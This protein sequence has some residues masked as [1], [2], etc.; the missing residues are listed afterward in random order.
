MLSRTATVT[1]VDAAHVTL[2]MSPQCEGCAACRGRCARWFGQARDYR[3]PRAISPAARIGDQVRVLAGERDVRRL[4]LR[5]FG[6]LTLGA[7]LG[8]LLAAV[9]APTLG[10]MTDGMSAL[11]ALSGMVLVLVWL[12]ARQRLRRDIPAWL[13]I[14]VVDHPL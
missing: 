2:R 6:L 3:L 14:E 13:N 4:A 1:A 10:I 12:R 5:Q 9:L 11:G 7:L 8:A